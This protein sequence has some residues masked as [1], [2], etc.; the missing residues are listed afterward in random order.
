VPV[1]RNNAV[2]VD[3]GG[4]GSPAPPT[5]QNSQGFG[6]TIELL[7]DQ[8]LEPTVTAADFTVLKNAV[9]DVVTAAV[10]MGR[11]VSLTLT[12]A[13]TTGDTVTVAYS[14]SSLESAATATLVL[15]FGPVSVTVGVTTYGAGD[16]GG[17]GGGIIQSGTSP[18]GVYSGTMTQ[19]VDPTIESSVGVGLTPAYRG[20]AYIV[21]TTFSLSRWSGI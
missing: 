17:V 12:T 2:P 4:G 5:L 16:L 20:R 11:K 19:L 18:V 3:D 7:F 14:G 10:V 21:H 15:P 8:F 1:E 13:F 9:A 6:P